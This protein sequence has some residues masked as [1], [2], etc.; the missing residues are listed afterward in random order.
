MRELALDRYRRRIARIASAGIEMGALSDELVDA[1]DAAIGFDGIC[2]GALDPTTLVP[3]DIGLLGHKDG[4]VTNAQAFS[5]TLS[6]PVQT[7]TLALAR[8]PHPVEILSQSYDGDVEQSP[9]YRHV[10]APQGFE[11]GL[12][13][14]LVCDGSCWGFIS[15]VRNSGR[16]DFSQRDAEIAE[17][18]APVLAR[19]LKRS[20][21]AHTHT[22]APPMAEPG[23][24]MLD[25]ALEVAASN[26]A[27]QHWLAELGA[28]NDGLPASL[29]AVAVV[30]LDRLHRA[31]GPAPPHLRLRSRG[32]AWLH[33]HATALDGTN[34][35]TV[36]IV[37]EP[38]R[39]DQLTPIIAHAYG[40]TPRER[41]VAQLVA[42]G[43]STAEIAEMLIIAPYTVKDH[44][45]AVFDK[46][47]VRNRRDL[48]RALSATPARVPYGRAETPQPHR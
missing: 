1:L 2:S 17:A 24:I 4:V 41:E 26:Y 31:P 11:H 34:G 20:T 45:K 40:L 25:Q 39:R 35:R 38:A 18:I 6:A 5:V 16:P 22:G 23:M 46:V 10:L 48:A 36:V 28:A 27:A 14:M 19:A 21:L 32:G 37:I 9:L 47:G 29:H 33:V 8:A 42:Q 43:A 15:F 12:R 3:T 13:A 44:L 7:T 30:A